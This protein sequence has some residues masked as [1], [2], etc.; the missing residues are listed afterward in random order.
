VESLLASTVERDLRAVDPS[1]K[2]LQIQCKSRLCRLR[3]Q[4]DRERQAAHFARQVYGAELWRIDAGA[5]QQV[6][7]QLRD[8]AN[9]D[10]AR[11]TADE[12]VARLRSRRASLLFSLRTGRVKPET[13]LPLA[14]LPSE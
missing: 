3:F 4:S 13:N 7:L 2:A 9:R 12:S 11:T 8:G 1:V 6:Y 10:L 5:Y 14:R